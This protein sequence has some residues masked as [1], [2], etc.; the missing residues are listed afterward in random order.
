MHNVVYP[1]KEFR[2][3]LAGISRAEG[4]AFERGPVLTAWHLRR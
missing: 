1:G 4:V 2:L 3:A